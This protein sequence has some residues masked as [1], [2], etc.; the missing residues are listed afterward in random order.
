MARSSNKLTA[1]AIAGIKAKGRYS[2]GGGLY[3]RVSPHL[4]KSWVFRWVRHRVENEMGL[5]RYPEVSLVEAREQ[6]FA[7]RRHVIAGRNP[8]TERDRDRI[9]GILFSAVIEEYLRVMSHRWANE[10]TRWQWQQTLK[11]FS[12]P[13]HRREI[14]QI[15]TSDVV[16]LLQPIWLETP[17]KA[18]KARMRLEAVLDYAKSKGWRDGENPAR[19]KGHLSNILPPRKKLSR[20]HHPAMRYDEVPAFVQDL[21]KQ[22]TIAAKGLLFT[23]LTCCRSGE[24]REA[25]WE[26]FDLEKRLWIIP[27]HQTKTKLDEHRVPLTDAMIEVLKPL[28][29]TSTSE[30]VFPGNKPK[31]PLS[32]MAFAQA[33]KRMGIANASPHGFRS[34]FR[35]WCGDKTDYARELAEACLAHKVGSQVELAYRRS[36]ALQKRRHL[37]QDWNDFVS[38]HSI[39]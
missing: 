10:K 12:K 22:E 29:E 19:W 17:E 35:D 11:D 16:K 5:G 28:N 14:A 6:A 25:K 1:I 36:D 30:Y 9:G 21:R 2:D 3:L 32:N 13:L 27:K 34:S 8:R 39:A 4:N 15:E 26:Q 24:V 37:M 18:A 38:R 31:R 23:I 33:M 7:A 20:G